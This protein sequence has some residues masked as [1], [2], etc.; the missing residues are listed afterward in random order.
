MTW[1][2]PVGSF[3]ARLTLRWTAAAGLLLLASHLAIYAGAR[4]FLYARLDRQVRTLIATEVASATDGITGVHL[5]E[6]SLEAVNSGIDD[7]AVQIFD[8]S[9]DVVVQSVWLDA[10]AP[11]IVGLDVVQAALR[12]EA[13]IV[14]TDVAGRQGRAAVLRA[15]RE[16][17][18]Y[19]VALALFTDD[20]DHT[21]S[22]LGWLLA[23][24][25]I[26]A[27]GLT[28]AIGYHLA[29][30]A[31]QPVEQITARAAHI[32]RGAFAA[33]LDPARHDDELGR[34]TTS[35]NAL[36]DRLHGAIE[37]NRRFAADAS[38]E[39]RGPI[40]AMAGQ[41][42]VTLR[43]DRSAEEYREAL[44][45]VRH[46]LST[47]TALIEDLILLVRATEGGQ[48]VMRRVVP[49]EPLV[50]ASRLRYEPAARVRQVALRVDVPDDLVAFVEPRLFARVMDNVF[51]NAV[52]F[53][54]EG[55][56]V[57]VFAR[58]QGPEPDAGDWSTN[59]VVIAVTDSG[60]GIPAADQERVF[61]RFRRLD[62]SRA[63]HTGGSGL[64]LAICRE[65]LTLLG[66]SIRVAHSSHEGTTM[67]IRVPGE[68]Q[69]ANPA[70]DA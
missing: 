40:T 37:A 22:D 29:S 8:P 68:R 46:R 3:R 57:V 52:K 35:L 49:L 42:D 28:G 21:L 55:G 44:G 39:L 43:H 70:A 13:P 25:W 16:G 5:H 45:L 58:A 61:E 24:V 17:Q 19:A 2:R 63:R 4:A 14:D 1:R 62:E 10:A 26:G 41:I 32:A 48:E 7:K 38:H 64:G 59:Q 15:A 47:L 54:R 34:M 51:S 9:G 30:R 12:G 65:V 23:G 69:V 50:N 11:P 67:E 36:L 18:A 56:S 66:G 53:N 31:L 33:R 20:I 60:P 27:L 6:P